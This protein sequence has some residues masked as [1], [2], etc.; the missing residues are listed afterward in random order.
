MG[1]TKLKKLDMTSVDLVRRGANQKA[2]ICLRKS[3]DEDNIPQGLWKSIQDAVSAWW[4]GEQDKDPMKEFNITKSSFIDA[5]EYSMESI[6]NDDTMDSIAKAE[7]AEESINQFS[8]ALFGEVMK[9]IGVYKATD[10]PDNDETYQEEESLDNPG[11]KASEDESEGQKA[12][13]NLEEGER[14]M[15]I[16]KS[17]FTPEEL[18][19]YNALIAKGVVEEEEEL[20]PVE[21]EEDEGE[22]EMHP[23]VKKA[24]ADVEEMRKNFEMK[25]LQE[26]AKKYSVL[27]KKEEELANTLY[28]MKKSSPENYNSYI[29][30]LDEQVG[31]VEKSG[32]FEEVGKSGHGFAPGGDVESKIGSI[33]SDIQKADPNMSR[34]EAINKAWEQNPELLAQYEEKL[35]GGR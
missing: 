21:D 30:L 17:R 28:A 34:Y 31:M 35:Y 29:A 24:L 1:K 33:A 5:L 20:P 6:M 13:Q 22:E 4:S 26:V 2:D 18:D 15:K 27:G 10:G 19:Q 3:A 25:E 23:E 11:E 16:D 14:E 12:T 32:L 7:M 8:E 9:T